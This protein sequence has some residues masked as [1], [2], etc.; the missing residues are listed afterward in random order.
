MEQQH[1]NITG[2]YKLPAIGL[3]TFTITDEA[4]LERAL[5]VAFETGYRHIDTAYY[6]QNEHIIGRVLKKWFES[7]K[8]K[9]EDVFITTKLPGCQ[10]PDRVET[11]L[12]KS[13]EDLQLDYVDLYLIHIPMAL[14]LT[15]GPL[16]ITLPMLP[17]DIVATW[18]K[19]EE[20]VDLGRCKTIGISNFN[21]RQVKKI[22]DNARIIPATNQVEL[23]IYLQQPELVKF[24]QD[25]GVV[26]VSYQTFGNPGVSAW[27]EKQNLPPRVVPDLFNDPVVKKLAT[28]YKKT[29]AQILLRFILQ[30]NIALIPK[31]ITPSRIKENFQ[32]FDFTLD[33]ADF[34]ELEKLDKGDAGRN[35]WFDHSEQMA[36]HPEH[37]FGKKPKKF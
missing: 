13:L 6:Y 8:L 26:V 4:E 14:D 34:K 19:L 25:N 1:F 18:K 35:N 28:K 37:P 29:S 33:K 27:L 5:D 21:I 12:K 36:N 7:G 31:S 2:G 20:Q 30:K 32:I 15:K 22:L 11:Y 3:G 10:P 23:H 16:S 17:S 24:C 9:R